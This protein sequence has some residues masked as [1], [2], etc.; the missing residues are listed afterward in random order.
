L[1]EVLASFKR[2]YPQVQVDIQRAITR[3][4]TEKVVDGSLDFGIVT[5]PIDNPRLETIT[6]HQDDMALIVS[7]SHRLASRRTVQMTELASEPFILHKIGTTTR[8]RLV[9]HFIDGGVKMKVTMELASI[10]T[11]KRFVSIGMGISIVPRLCIAKEL[12]EGSLRAL[13]IRDARFQRRLGL[14]YNKGRYQSQAARAFVTLISD[15]Q[16]PALKAKS[17]TSKA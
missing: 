12:E 8:E 5:L 1:P 14:I 7:P 4:I 6:I 13:A 9:K 10:E 2:A 17:K 11:I 16:Q 3:A 15:K